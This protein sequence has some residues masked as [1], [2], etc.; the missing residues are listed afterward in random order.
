MDMLELQEELENPAT[1]A[2]EDRLEEIAEQAENSRKK[3][4]KSIGENL[5]NCIDSELVDQE[6]LQSLRNQLNTIRYYDRI[7]GTVED[8]LDKP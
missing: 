5:D 2:D 8:L 4:L 1:R 3:A 7:L 6:S